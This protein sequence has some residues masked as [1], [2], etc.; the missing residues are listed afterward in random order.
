MS[1]AGTEAVTSATGGPDRPLVTAALTAFNAAD[2]IA[3]ALRSAVGQDWPALEVLVVDDGSSD[4]TAAV[5]DAFIHGHGEAR[6][7][8]RLVRNPRNMGVAATRNRILREAQGEIIAFFDDDD[9]SAP[10]RITRQVARLL[11]AEREAGHDLILCHAARDQVHPGGSIHYERTM[12]CEDAPL[13]DA[14]AVAQR[15]LFGRVS[16]NVIGSVATCSQ[17]ARR[18]VYERLGGFDETLRRSEDTDLA[19]R[20]ARAGGTIAG[21]AEPLVRQ[22]M[23]PGHEKRLHAEHEAFVALLDK[24]ADYLAAHG[25]RD[26]YRDWQRLRLLDLQGRRVAVAA[27]LLMLGLRRPVKL[28]RKL[29]WSLPARSTRRS[30]RAW[31]RHHEQGTV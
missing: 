23:T 4:D 11:A 20:V 30:Q 17:L 1:R 5:V 18:T 12:G 3:E 8:V 7:P 2:T 16:G 25:W 15:I 10:H 27:G 9:V 14:D 6:P 22:R 13:P 19:I 24:H 26:F 31:N 21:V 28:M 29:L